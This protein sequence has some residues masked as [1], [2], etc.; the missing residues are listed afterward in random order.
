MF[1]ALLAPEDLLFRAINE[2]VIAGTLLKQ[3]LELHPHLAKPGMLAACTTGFVE[4][5]S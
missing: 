1:I 4:E 5:Q 2:R 3:V